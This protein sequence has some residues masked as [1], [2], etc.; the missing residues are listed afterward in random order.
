MADRSPHKSPVDG[1][2]VFV[3]VLIAV[4]AIAA[5]LGS[6]PLTQRIDPSMTGKAENWLGFKP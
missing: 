6:T 4:V 3:I 2:I 1:A 5:Y